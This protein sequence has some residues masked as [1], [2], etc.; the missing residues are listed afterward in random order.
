MRYPFF[1]IGH[2][3]LCVYC[4]DPANAT[5]H[6]IPVSFQTDHPKPPNRKTAFG[7]VAFCCR[8]C[9][10]ILSNRIFDSFDDRCR[11]VSRSINRDVKPVLWTKGEVRRLDISLRAYIE[12]EQAYRLW[13][14]FRSDWYQSRD[15]LLNLEQLSWV[16]YLNREH[17]AFHSELF[18]FFE[19][20]L[21]WVKGLYR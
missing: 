10:S 11:E 8:S 12:R 15:Y 7:P 3:S 1:K 13:M 18:K 9:N 20:T 2:H 19:I 5:D 4:G 16:P 6:V 21:I 17:K 14:R